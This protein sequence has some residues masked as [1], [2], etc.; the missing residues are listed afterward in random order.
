MR[1]LLHDQPLRKI[2]HPDLHD[3]I[4]ELVAKLRILVPDVELDPLL[5]DDNGEANGAPV[6]GSSDGAMPTFTIKLDDPSGNSFVET[7]G[8]LGDP[9]W[10]KREYGRDRA[11]DEALGLKHDEATD[12]ATSHYPEEVLSFPGV[13]SLC[14]SE[15]E[16]LMKK[17]NI[18]H[19]KVRFS[20]LSRG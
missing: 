14:G 20:L 15:L 11:Q 7:R 8:G 16:T 19:F 4:A 17:V 18:P 5:E 3:K 9:K 10:A 2:Q 13:C 6:A 12:K 1:D